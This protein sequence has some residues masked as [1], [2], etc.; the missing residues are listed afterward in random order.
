MPE[1][2]P[3]LIAAHRQILKE[4]EALPKSA[5]GAKVGPIIVALNQDFAETFDTG[6]WFKERIRFKEKLEKISGGKK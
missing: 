4:I 3:R 5:R 2:Q 1:R 6:F